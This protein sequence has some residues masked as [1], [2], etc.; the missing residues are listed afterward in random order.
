M[1][2]IAVSMCRLASVSRRAGASLLATMWSALDASI[3][4]AAACPLTSV[5]AAAGRTRPDAR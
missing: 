4:T 2:E 5:V 1:C 3:F